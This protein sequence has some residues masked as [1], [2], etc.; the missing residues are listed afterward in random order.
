MVI[1]MKNKSKIIISVALTLTMLLLTASHFYAETIYTYNGYSYH[2]ID[3]DTISLCGWDNRS[4]S[5]VIPSTLLNSYVSEIDDIAFRDNKVIKSIDM[6]DADS[7]DRIGMMAFDG[8]SSIDGTVVI[9][10]G[11][12]SIGT[13]AFQNCSSVD[14]LRYNASA[15]DI[16]AQFFYKAS[17]LSEVV[18]TDGVSS[19]GKLAFAECPN[20]SFIR[21]PESVTYI[22]PVAFQNSSNTVI[23]CYY[24]SYAAQFARENGIEYVILNPEDI[25]APTEPPTEAPT[26]APTE[27]VTETPEPTAAPT[28]LPTESMKLLLGDADVDGMVDITDATIIQRVLANIKVEKYDALAADVDGNGE[29]DNIDV[30][31]IMRYCSQIP[32]AYSIGEW[33]D[34]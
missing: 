10:S 20:L 14:S 31:F 30:T 33:I 28:E 25:P 6:Y 32:T 3:K 8:C 21:V 16:P 22:H 7:L 9:P 24:G 29:V 5:L 23:Y 27:P 34:R 17:E 2:E 1:F 18:I 15:A 12:R 26:E 13:G 4:A 11:V 19:I